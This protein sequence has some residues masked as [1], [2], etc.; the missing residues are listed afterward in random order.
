MSP[1]GPLD[2]RRIL[3]VEDSYPQAMDA[4][5]WLAEAG[6][7]VLGPA[8]SVA[9]ARALLSDE[10]VDAAVLDVNL[11]NGADYEIASSLV[12]L[13]IPFVLATGY[14]VLAIDPRFRDAPLVSKP[15]AKQKLLQAI[16]AL[17]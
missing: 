9:A 7:R 16:L 11:G 12:D 1:K 14:D 15:V 3:L 10:P 13:G 5:E 2:G 6:A 4:S 17:I 8:P